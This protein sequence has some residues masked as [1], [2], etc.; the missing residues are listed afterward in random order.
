MPKTVLRLQ[1][2]QFSETIATE[3][4]RGLP[5]EIRGAQARMDE[6]KNL[7][8]S[9]ITGLYDGLTEWYW[10]MGEGRVDTIEAIIE[11]ERSVRDISGAIVFDR[12]RR[13]HWREGLQAPGYDGVGGLFGQML[14]D[15]RFTALAVLS[16]EMYLP[17]SFAGLKWIEKIDFKWF[18][19][20]LFILFIA[21]VALLNQAYNW[22]LF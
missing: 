7:L 9:T 8:A 3:R 16:N 4:L 12:G 10:R 19:F 2:E 5:E 21:G 14:G 22:V 13:I 17:Y 6:A 11:A 20:L 1:V 15:S 18:Q